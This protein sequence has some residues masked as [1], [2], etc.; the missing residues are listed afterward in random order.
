MIAIIG[1]LTIDSPLGY[2]FL[3]KNNYVRNYIFEASIKSFRHILEYCRE[4]NIRSIILLGDIFEVKD[5]IKNAIKNKLVEVFDIYIDDLSFLIVSGN[6][7]FSPDGQST[8]RWLEAYNNIKIVYES[9]VVEF[10]GYNILCIPYT[11]NK[12]DIRLVLRDKYKNKPDFVCAHADVAGFFMGQG[13]RKSEGLDPCCFKKYKTFLGHIHK[14]Q[15]Y[16]NIIV[17]GSTYLTD[18][19]ESGQRNFVVYDRGIIKYVKIPGFIPRKII[20]IF[21]ESDIKQLNS[22]DKNDFVRIDLNYNMFKHIEGIIEKLSKVKYYV[23]NH[24]NYSQEVSNSS[25]E[26]NK[27]ISFTFRKYIQNELNSI[28]KKDKKIYRLV[29]NKILNIGEE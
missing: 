14:P 4:N 6:H 13:A 16:K 11:R 20:P 12:K 10:G 18:W 1:D 26:V 3:S 9:Q 29:V 23:F 5:R 2:N 24:I 19:G 7:D 21:E 15:E 25:L 8:I 27:D 28:D 17:L 22:L